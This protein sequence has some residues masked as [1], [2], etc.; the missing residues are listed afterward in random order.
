MPERSLLA[1]SPAPR[2]IGRDGSWSLEALV[3]ASAVVATTKFVGL[4]VPKL[5]LLN[6]N[7]RTLGAFGALIRQDRS[8]LV[9]VPALNRYVDPA[10]PMGKQAVLDQIIV[11]RRHE[12]TFWAH[13]S[14]APPTAAVP[15]R[16]CMSP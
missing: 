13:R 4:L 8:H 12:V 15:T 7:R 14:P 1:W 5:T 16:A 2:R 6:S 3:R 11:E 10:M 9:F